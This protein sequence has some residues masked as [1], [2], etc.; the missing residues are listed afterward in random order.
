MDIFPKKK[1]KAF[2]IWKL[3]YLCKTILPKNPN[4]L[5]RNEGGKQFLNMAEKLS[6]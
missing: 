2:M 1:N 4:Y 3:N 5:R 6:R